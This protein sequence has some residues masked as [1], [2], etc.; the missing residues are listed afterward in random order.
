MKNIIR[1]C[2][3]ISLL[4]NSFALKAQNWVFIGT[5]EKGEK[6]YFN[7]SDVTTSSNGVPPSW[8]ASFR[9]PHPSS[10]PLHPAVVGSIISF[11]A[12]ILAAAWFSTSGVCFNYT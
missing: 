9:S 5:S 2:L 3:I 8:V 4:A 12:P 10:P 1:L 11:A 6:T 7:N